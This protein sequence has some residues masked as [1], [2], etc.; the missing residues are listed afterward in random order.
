MKFLPFC[1]LALVA[2]LTSTTACVAQNGASP[3]PRGMAIK[4]GGIS[5][6]PVDAQAVGKKIWQ[7]ECSGT[8]EG[9]TSWN[10]GEDFPSLGIGH[11]IWYVDGREGPFEESFPQLINFMRGLGVSGIPPV[12]GSN[13][14][15]WKSRESFLARQNSQEL[16]DL[17]TFLSKTVG[18]QTAFIVSRLEA[19][20]PKMLAATSGAADKER[21][22]R[23]FYAVAESRQGVYALIDYVNFKGEGTNPNER[24]KG[25]GWGLRDVL[26]AMEGAP[27]GTAAAVEFGEAGKRTLRRRIANSPPERGES[28]WEAGWVNRCKTYQRSF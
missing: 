13:G 14:S 20:M 26:L 10:K 1:H 16:R 17:R 25:Q 4:P 28:R 5:L 9:L 19:A 11:F 24:Y 12:A 21:L 6:S 15:P 2:V 7:N 3:S 23:N 18:T 27:R 8:V 22:R